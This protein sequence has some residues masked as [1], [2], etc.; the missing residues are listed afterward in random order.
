MSHAFIIACF[1]L[2]KTLKKTVLEKDKFKSIQ[3]AVNY[4]DKFTDYSYNGKTI[5]KQK[6]FKVK[7]I[8][9]WVNETTGRSYVGKSINLHQRFNQYFSTI[10][11]KL[12]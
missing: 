8:Y 1:K 12:Q 7:G 2:I 5:I 11:Y 3:P 4:T 10:L 6:Y 9:L